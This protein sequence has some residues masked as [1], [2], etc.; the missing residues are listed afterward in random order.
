M[1]ANYTLTL[2]AL[3]LLLALAPSA[4]AQSFHLLHTFE[5]TDGARPGALAMD[6]A[7]N[8]YGSTS[9]GG[10][11]NCA[12]PGNSGCG[13]VFE[14]SKKNSSWAFATLYQ[15]QSYAD[16]W[17][18]NSPLTVGAGGNLYGTT[19]DGGIEEGY[20]SVFRLRS[21]C[22][23]LGCN[24]IVWNKTILYRF[25]LCDGAGT[26]GGL[27]FDAA[28]NLYGTTVERCGHTGQ[29]YE[30][31]PAQNLDGT[32]TKNT[33]HVFYG[34]PDGQWPEGP[35]VFDQAGNLYGS[36]V[37]GGISNLG[38]VYC[39]SLHG[40]YWS[41]SVLHS[42][43]GSDGKDPI[44]S[45]IFDPAGNLYGTTFGD[46][47]PSNAFELKPS[48]GGTC[49]TWSLA[50]SYP[51]PPGQAQYLNSGLVM[52]QDGNLYGASW[53]GGASGFGSIYKLTVAGDDGWSYSSVYDFTGGSDG[54]S[55]QGP[56]VLDGQGHLFGTAAS[57]GDLNCNS[58]TGCGTVWVITLP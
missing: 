50:R 51:F 49:G 16:G 40:S 4:N 17:S 18:P 31:S 9:I 45:L 24:Q 34:M 30:L 14:L 29:V 20:G 10:L 27:V 5:G 39:M 19:L 58:G 12:N 43:V 52:D 55:P 15:F 25:G 35:V 42:F 32:W 3:A 26:N 21:S 23:D 57:G 11:R 36:T 22:K 53:S 54:Y 13:T 38:T 37:A 7:G 46:S 33:L 1:K 56:L 2:V 41:E 47:Q 48:G 28:G 8:L 44:G 6:P